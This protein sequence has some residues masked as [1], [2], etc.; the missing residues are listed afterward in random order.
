M[1]LI[2]SFR[3]N[4][5]SKHRQGGDS[6]LLSAVVSPLGFGR[7]DKYTP[8]SAKIGF[9]CRVPVLQFLPVLE[10]DRRPGGQP[11]ERQFVFTC[12]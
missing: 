5:R 7:N 2:L 8:I 3:F 4:D 10:N 11:I 12:R 1:M 6:R 9:S